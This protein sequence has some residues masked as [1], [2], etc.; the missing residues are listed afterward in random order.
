MLYLAK[1]LNLEPILEEWLLLYENPE[2]IGEVSL[3]QCLVSCRSTRTPIAT[4]EEGTTD[5]I[6]SQKSSP[7]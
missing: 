4:L 3:A 2:N 1:K 5:M 7:E 6:P